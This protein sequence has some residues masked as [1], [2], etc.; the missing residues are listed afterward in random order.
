MYPTLKNN[1][2][3]IMD[4]LSKVERYDIIV[5]EHHETSLVKRVIALEGEKVKCQ[6]GQIFI[7]KIKNGVETTFILEEPY[8][9]DVKTP[10]F[11]ETIVGKGELF[12]LGDNRTNSSDSSNFGPISK[13]SIKGVVHNFFIKNK[14]TITKIF[15]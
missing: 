9:K 5:F 10:N 6:D 7:T 2:V 12:V 3:L 4:K 14:N 1:D 13:S 8:L 15:G 11:A